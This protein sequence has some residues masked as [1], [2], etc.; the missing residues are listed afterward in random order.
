MM[1]KTTLKRNKSQWHMGDFITSL[2]FQ[3]RKL[4]RRAHELSGDETGHD[5]TLRCERKDMIGLL[6]T[7]FNPGR[8]DLNSAVFVQHHC[9][10]RALA[11][12]DISHRDASAAEHKMICSLSL[13]G[14][15]RDEEIIMADPR[16]CCQRQESLGIR[17]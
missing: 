7:Q 14:Q 10:M 1:E 8:S 12:V 13:E 3:Q 4:V 6:W 11:C 2:P 5:R 9:R 15:R 16:N 17:T